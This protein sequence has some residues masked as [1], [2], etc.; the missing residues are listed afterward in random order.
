MCIYVMCV[1]DGEI[2]RHTDREVG[3]GHRSEMSR[4][5]NYVI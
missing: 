4:L 5:E 2:D 1:R 3:R